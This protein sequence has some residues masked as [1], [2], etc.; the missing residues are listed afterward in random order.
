VNE[1]T[2]EVIGLEPLLLAIEEAT[3]G[4]ALIVE[5][6]PQLFEYFAETN[7]ENFD[8]EGGLTGGFEPLTE[9]YAAWK[10]RRVGGKPI[11]QFE[12]RL[13]A[14]LTGRTGDTIYEVRP[15]LAEFGSSLPYAAAQDA[16][17]ALI[18]LDDRVG[19]GYLSVLQTVAGGRAERLGL[20]SL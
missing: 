1:P 15:G 12:G 2:V 20:V 13:Y 8:T 18:P 11:E 4:D 9:E 7:K 19:A 16:R 3:D 10:E 17:N 6:A 5:A 14:S